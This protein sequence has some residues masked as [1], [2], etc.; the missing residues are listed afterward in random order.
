MKRLLTLLMLILAALL[1]SCEKPAPPA[2]LLSEL[3]NHQ[4]ADRIAI[5][6]ID[7][8]RAEIIVFGVKP[9]LRQITVSPQDEMKFKQEYLERRRSATTSE[10]TDAQQSPDDKW[11]TYRTRDNQFVLADTAEGKVRRLFDGKNVLTALYW[12]PNAE[13][14]F[15]VEKAGAWENGE[16]NKYLADGRDIMVYRVRDGKKGRVYQVCDGY[17]Y[18]RFGWVRVPSTTPVP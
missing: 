17:P 11:L 16:C 18:T 9:L 4:R 5:G 10:G 15:Y 3:M 12:S 2:D 7:N 13:Y 1:S 6:W 14:L 8:Q